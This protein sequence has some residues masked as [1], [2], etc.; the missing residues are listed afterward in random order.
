ML[1]G[2]WVW[3]GWDAMVAIGTLALAAGTGVL[4]WFTW[5]AVTESRDQIKLA[6]REVEAVERQTAAL[7]E[8]TQA[9][10]EQAE[11]TERQAETSAASLEAAARPVLVGLLRPAT[12]TRL[13]DDR[14]GELE[15]LVYPGGYAVPV[16]PLAV[17]YEERGDMVYL[18]FRVQNIGLGVAF[19][20]RAALL[21]RTA[22]PVRIAPPIIPPNETARVLVALTLR[23]SDGRYTDV[24]EITKT[25]RGFVQATVG[26]FYTGASPE[27]ALTTELT[28]SELPDEQGWLITGAKIWDGDTRADLDTPEERPLLA[29]T[30]NIG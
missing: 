11:A 23:Q 27:L 21:T 29:S 3:H 16:H 9:V 2:F 5:R 14:A 25:G 10:R 18:S 13:D 26:L 24:N 15:P 1:A 4:A 12:I 22:Y 19:V 17:H 7:A 20:Q 28:L 30:S 8:Q 6:T